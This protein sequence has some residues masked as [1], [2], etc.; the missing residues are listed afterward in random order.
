MHRLIF[1]YNAKAGKLNGLKDSL[2]K[3]V[4]PNTYECSLCSLTHGFWGEHEKWREFCKR[5]GLLTEFYHKDDCLE[6]FPDIDLTLLPM[7]LI[8]EEGFEKVLMN[9][10]EIDAC[11]DLPS[12]IDVLDSKLLT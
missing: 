2:H 11:I 9:Q 5:S 4:S 6:C 10:G 12:L 1:I 3:L 7:I 8:G